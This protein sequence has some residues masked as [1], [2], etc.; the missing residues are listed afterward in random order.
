MNPPKPP[1]GGV[2]SPASAATT[3][4]AAPA[5]GPR[6]RTTDRIGLIVGAIVALAVRF[7]LIVVIL[8]LL[9]TAGL[10]VFTVRNIK[11]NTDPTDML[12]PEL[13]FR[14]SY[15]AYRRAFPVFTNN[16]V[17]VI[18]ADDA[19][20][21]E[22]GAEAL[23]ARL[24]QDR[25]R[26]NQIFY[27]EGDPFFRR[28]GL[29]YLGT[30]DLQNL[31]SRLSEAQP[32]LS[33]LARDPSIRGLFEVLGLGVDALGTPDG[34][35]QQMVR[36]LDRVT[37]VIAARDADKARTLSWK[38]LMGGDSAAVDRRRL[39]VLQPEL[40]YGTFSP[41]SDAIKQIRRHAQELG[42]TPENG[43]RVR[44]TGSAAIESEEIG[45]IAENTTLSGQLSFLVVAVLLIVC[46][47]SVRLVVA[48]LVT[49]VVGFIWTAAFAVA[50]VGSFNLISVAFAVLFIGI[51]IDFS[52]HFGLRC[53]EMADHGIKG[54]ASLSAAGRSIGKAL[55]LMAGTA[56][57][58]FF[59]FLPTDYRG[60]SELGLIA[61]FSM[62]AAFI[63]N[64]TFLPAVLALWPA[65]DKPVP[66]SRTA[67]TL[68]ES[69]H[70]LWRNS[71]T[72]VIAAAVL[73]VI[74]LGLLSTARFDRNPLNLKDP[75]T[76]SVATAIELLKNPRLR[77]GTISILVD[78][79]AEI[80]PLVARLKAL[81]SV[82]AVR[83]IYDYV[84]GDQ[85]AKLD[86]I[87]E[88]AL[89]MTPILAP[90]TRV[91]QPDGE[92]RTVVIATLRDKVKRVL[93]QRRAGPIEAELRRFHA[94]LDK[95][96]LNGT[97][98]VR[99]AALEQDLVGSLQ[100]RLDALKIALQ[101]KPVDFAALPEALRQRELS[102]VGKVR[103]EVVPK[104]DLRDNRALRRFVDEVSSVAPD[105]TGGP[106]VE[107]KAGDAVVEAF[108]I[109]SV[110]AFVLIVAGLLVLLRSLG[111]L[112]LILAPLFLASALT[113]G[114]AV[115]AGL[116]FNFANIIVLPLLI[117]LGVSSGV[118][119]VLRA[120][121]DSTI[122]LLNTT[123]PRA[124]L[125]SAFTTIAAFA[126]LALSSHWGQ[127]SMGLL[128][129]IAISVNLVCYLLVLP[130]LLAYVEQRRLA[131]VVAKAS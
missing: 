50:A 66:V 97:D 107:L 62:I 35:P 8:T 1:S 43:V 64:V 74:G 16:L 54:R 58:G 87:E 63:T 7:P 69:E 59:S 98:E 2:S 113:V 46:F 33:T 101:A 96:L 121:R 91:A 20:R 44:V 15:E 131:G 65:R 10:G 93:D 27:P 19:D 125:F 26:Y 18:E 41:A 105:A 68:E 84:P 99:T 37:A 72:I 75:T 21:A 76:E 11:I 109:A 104:D 86:L 67:A 94:A 80:A 114:I 79:V 52:I 56:A 47:G 28:N 48:S 128:L 42:L 12:S 129:L 30:K 77:V 106:V 9:G 116:S 34:Q 60:V 17:I 85:P 3:R 102:P 122:E 120:R 130:A 118:H 23:Y 126:S 36:V 40:N 108:V 81:S 123:T 55:A 110:I 49:L 61:G 39:I 51:G 119:L 13:A 103:I 53:R 71:R 73:G 89:Q 29:L 38:E 57:L 4:G 45:S 100:R 124:V 115:A 5:G 117:G 32:L 78:S 90:A 92:Q 31:S 22:D 25:G 111:D 6:R 70:W 88:I 127:A 14:K 82:E 24:Q 112:L 95:F 83:S